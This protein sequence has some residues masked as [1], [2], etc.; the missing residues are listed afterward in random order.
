MLSFSPIP[1][2]YINTFNIKTLSTRLFSS[3]TSITHQIATK[4]SEVR[5]LKLAGIIKS[6]LA[7][8]IAELLAL[9]ASLSPPPAPLA[10]TFPPSSYARKPFFHQEILHQST[11]SSARVTRITTPHGSFLTPSFVAVATNG[12]IK[13]VTIDA[14]KEEKQDLMFCNSYHLLLQ[15]GPDVIAGAGGIHKFM[16]M[17]EGTTMGPI[18]TDSGGFQV[19]S[20]RYGTVFEDLKEE[21]SSGSFSDSKDSL[22]KP[23]A[24]LKRASVRPSTQ[25]A[26]GNS[27]KPAVTVTEEGVVFRSY[28]DGVMVPL[29]PESTIQAQKKYGSDIIIPLDELPSYGVTGAG[30]KASVDLTHRW[31]ARSLQEHLKDINS[32]QG[33]GQAIY[34]IV[35]GGVDKDLRKYSVEYITSLP[36]DGF[37]IGGSLG[38][39]REE[40]LDMLKFV[41]PLVKESEKLPGQYNKPVHLLG[42]ADEPS[43]LAAAPLGID[44]FDSCFPTRLARHGTLLTSKGRLHIKSAKYSKQYGVPIDE[45]CDCRACSVHDR[46]YMNHLLRAREPVFL[47]LAT[48]HNIKHM[49]RVMEQLRD[50]IMNDKV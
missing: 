30:L 38:G 5:A 25:E 41:M 11:K 40:M 9:K 20:L 23:K 29:T 33:E 3:M 46:A 43:I 15:P 37:C 36:F 42:I 50:D 14:V 39:N 22:A 6:D 12:A 19:F 26:R 8:H 48:R 18:I 16:G 28:R 34:G 21:T 7:P 1:V 4:A 35:H 45:G 31:E 24:E 10:A 13:G 44:T 47:E 17:R 2:Q 32:K 49:N 27:T